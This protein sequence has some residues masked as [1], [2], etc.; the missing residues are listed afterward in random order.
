MRSFARILHPRGQRVRADASVRRRH[1]LQPP[2]TAQTAHRGLL[3]LQ[4]GRAQF[5]V[6]AGPGGRR[7][8]P[9][10][11]LHGG[12]PDHVPEPVLSRR[13]EGR[14]PAA[15]PEPDRGQAQRQAVHR[16][17]QCA[18]D[19]PHL[20]RQRE[21]PPPAAGRV[22][23]LPVSCSGAETDSA[24]DP[25]EPVHPLRGDRCCA[26]RHQEGLPLAGV[27]QLRRVQAALRGR[28]GARAGAPDRVRGGQPTNP[29]RALFC[30]S[31]IYRGHRAP[32]VHA[33][34]PAGRRPVRIHGARGRQRPG[35]AADVCF[36]G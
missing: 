19:G 15:A 3:L 31:A 16:P 13:A 8:Q 9:P 34:Q 1:L 6:P 20:R 18:V 23:L 36:A 10:E 29:H 30:Q 22:P 2:E 27:R 33:A 26:G 11:L 21:P 25:D 5:P 35:E 7:G 24:Q 32:A 12:V 4:R 28:Q 14:D 17:A